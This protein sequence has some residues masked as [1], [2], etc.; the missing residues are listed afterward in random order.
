MDSAGI[1]CKVVDRWFDKSC[2]AAVSRLEKDASQIPI[3][4]DVFKPLEYLAKHLDV[5][6]ETIDSMK[7]EWIKVCGPVIRSAE[8]TSPANVCTTLETALVDVARLLP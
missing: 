5:G 7:S 2:P 4:Q 3:C 6:E 1:A 8:S